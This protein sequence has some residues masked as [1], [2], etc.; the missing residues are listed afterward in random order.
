M[1]LILKNYTVTITLPPNKVAIGHLHIGPGID[2]IYHL[3]ILVYDMYKS[4][5]DARLPYL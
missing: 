5:H 2:L 1:K 3:Y 4:E